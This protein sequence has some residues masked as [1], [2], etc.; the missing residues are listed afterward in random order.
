MMLR[1]L[2]R[3]RIDKLIELARITNDEQLRESL[4]DEAL[5]LLNVQQGQG[6]SSVDTFINSKVIMNP[7]AKQPRAE[8]YNAY[9]KYC[10]ENGLPLVSNRQLYKM[11]EEAGY[12]T[13]YV[14]NGVRYITGLRL[15]ED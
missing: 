1:S 3:Y 10:E 6:L 11:L 4:I 2:D 12:K 15:K 13:N 8:L 9:S 5:T 14:T 7:S